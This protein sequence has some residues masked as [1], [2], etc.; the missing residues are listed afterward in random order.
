MIMKHAKA[1]FAVEK[2]TYSDYDRKNYHLFFE[3]CTGY[4]K[5]IQ[6]LTYA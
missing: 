1:H 3:I 2:V 6:I 4:T 5:D